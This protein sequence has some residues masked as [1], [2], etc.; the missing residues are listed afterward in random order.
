MIPGLFFQVCACRSLST[1]IKVKQSAKV[2]GG[3]DDERVQTVY[4]KESEL[5]T[6]HLVEPLRK[7]NVI[8]SHDSL[9]LLAIF[10]ESLVRLG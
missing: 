7:H 8:L 5:L 6:R 10:H 1:W 4:S 9:R 2:K 3:G